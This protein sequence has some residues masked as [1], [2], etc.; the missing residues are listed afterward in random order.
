[1][2]LPSVGDGIAAEHE[3]FLHATRS[4][5]QPPHSLE[6]IAPSLFLAELIEAGFSGRVEI[7]VDLASV[8]TQ[9]CE[10]EGKSILI[11][12]GAG[13]QAALARWLPGYRL[14][15]LDDLYKCAEVRSDIVAA[16]LGRG[17][18]P[19]PPDVLENCRK[20]E[21]VGV[22]A[23]SVAR[24]APEAL[25]RSTSLC[26]MQVKPTPTSVAE[27]ALALAIL[28]RRRAFLLS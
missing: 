21:V 17:A 22:V 8:A 6:A 9:R 5:E 15:T 3:A 16:I 23:L 2:P 20:L 26:S 10:R 1:M 28:A 13:L 11:S 24:H 18:P 4:G 14:A 19:L 12:N 27:F 25:L 7:P